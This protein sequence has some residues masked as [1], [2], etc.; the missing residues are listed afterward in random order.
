MSERSFQS[1]KSTPSQSSSTTLSGAS[2]RNYASTQTSHPAQSP[3]A[4]TL[5]RPSKSPRVTNRNKSAACPPPPAGVPPHVNTIGPERRPSGSQGSSDFDGV[6]TTLRVMKEKSDASERAQVAHITTLSA[7][8][9]E[10]KKKNQELLLRLGGRDQTIAELRGKVK[11]AHEKVETAHKSAQKLR[12]ELGECEAKNRV[13]QG[14]ISEQRDRIADLKVSCEHGLDTVSR[15]QKEMKEH[16][17]TEEKKGKELEKKLQASEQKTVELE[18]A[19]TQ[20]KTLAAEEC[21]ALRKQLADTEAREDLLKKYE[22]TR[23]NAREAERRDLARLRRQ[24]DELQQR[25]HTAQG[26]IDTLSLEKEILTRE[27]NESLSQRLEEQVHNLQAV[28]NHSRESLQQH[29]ENHNDL[30]AGFLASLEHILGDTLGQQDHKAGIAEE[31]LAALADIQHNSL[32]TQSK[33]QDISTGLD[34]RFLELNKN[35]C[36]TMENILESRLH[37]LESTMEE[38]HGHLLSKDDRNEKAALDGLECPSIHG[39]M[40]LVEEYEAMD[41][42]AGKEPAEPTANPKKSYLCVRIPLASTSS[43]QDV[44]TDYQPDC[45]DELVSATAKATSTTQTGVDGKPIK[46]PDEVYRSGSNVDWVRRAGQQDRAMS[47]P[48]PLMSRNP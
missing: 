12:D 41:D 17:V 40:G 16:K 30:L 48:S 7:E 1:V 10:E 26:V 47:V 29:R 18:Q 24:H 42:H 33:V 45:T 44:F 35:V 36:Q 11:T 6:I 25:L 4:S 39:L 20:Q 32:L 9:R 8:L 15:L 23:R 14:Q 31:T 19:L 5:S 46:S 28:T 34:E 3:T 22:I 2:S 27:K 37:P 43:T 13:F 21:K 38:I